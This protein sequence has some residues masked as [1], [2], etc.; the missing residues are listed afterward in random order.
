MG[1]VVA[2]ALLAGCG[3]ATATQHQPA[4]RGVQLSA[5][6]TPWDRVGPGWLLATWNPNKGT[7]PG[8]HAAGNV[9]NPV[10][11]IFLVDPAGGRYLVARY[12][13]ENESLVGWSGDARR[14]LLVDDV[15]STR[16]SSI[17]IATG[18]VSEFALPA[19]NT[20]FFESVAYTRPDGLALLITTQTDNAQLLQRY[21]LTGTLQ[22]TYPASFSE[23]GTYE[24]SVLSSPDGL[25]LALGAKEGIALLDNDGSVVSQVRV[26]GVTY[27]DV[28]RWWATNVVLAS[29]A[30][31]SSPQRLYE[32][33]LTGG[34]ASALTAAPA[35]TGPDEGDENAWAI[36]SAVYLQD[37]GGC[38]YQYLA[39]LQ[40][41]RL[42]KP[43][44]VPGVVRGDSVFVL[45]TANG[46]LA[47]QATVACGSGESALW[48]NPSKNTST[49][50][51]GPPLNRGSVQVALPYPDPRG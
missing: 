30:S 47:L 16:I 8:T 27:C 33:P 48:F 21:S 36:G 3:S 9:A 49:V 43:V 41:D 50:V 29:C 10:N 24:G 4:A 42:T 20:V 25:Q 22:R 46:Q 12:T 6:A 31:S 37:A 2:G 23:V 5:S 18:K 28:K 26:P 15:S 34:T 32:I 40:P 1:A 7:A 38:G 39:R 35:V 17:D 14:A 44:V 51:L 19:S 11:S 45:G 13:N